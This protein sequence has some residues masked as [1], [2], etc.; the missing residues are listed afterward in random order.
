MIIY[1]DNSHFRIYIYFRLWKK[2][3]GLYKLV[4]ESSRT[5]V[6][7][8]CNL[9]HR[10]R[11]W[12]EGQLVFVSGI[13]ELD[14]HVFLDLLFSTSLFF[15][16]DPGEARGCSTNSLVIHWLIRWFSQPFPPTAVRRRHAQ[17]VR[18]STYKI[19]YVMVIKNSLNPKGHQN[20][21]SGSKVTA[22]LLKG[23]ILPINGASSGKVCACGLRSRLVNIV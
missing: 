6:S 2:G 4:R 12:C 22:V 3:A 17:T 9:N 11:G 5:F 21:I 14:L 18:D 7:G 23:Y 15:L 10:C 1:K 19:D 8:I 20:P 13:C 16:A